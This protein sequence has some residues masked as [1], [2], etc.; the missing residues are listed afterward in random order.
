MTEP[1]RR[2]RKP[3]ASPAVAFAAAL[4]VTGICAL[5]P[6]AIVTAPGTT[7]W[8][9]LGCDCALTSIVHV[10]APS[11]ASESDS[12]SDFEAA[13]RLTFMSEYESETGSVNSFGSF[14]ASRSTSPE[15]DVRT[16]ASTVRAVSAHAGAAVETSAD[17]T[18]CG[19]QFGWRW[20]R[21]AAAPATCGAAMLVPS[22]TANGPPAL[23]SVAERICPPGAPTSGFSRWPNAVRPAEEKLVTT[24]PRP[25]ERSRGPPPIRT[26]VRPPR[27]ARKARSCWPS[28]SAIIP[29]RT[30]SWTGIGLASPGRLST[31]TIPMPPAA[32]T[33]AL[34]SAKVQVPRET[35]A[36]APFSEPPGSGLG[37]PSRFPGGPQRSRGTG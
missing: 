29:P 32:F 18:C 15:P 6:G 13:P 12:S 35:S 1:R 3:Y 9:P 30:S 7:I 24:P 4:A 11:P 31:I 27:P 5:P 33:R 20:S 26:V 36:I 28:R 34:L 37:P 16:G 17:L 21:S 14:A 8:T 2:S 10:P 25:V 19:D 23:G 22:K